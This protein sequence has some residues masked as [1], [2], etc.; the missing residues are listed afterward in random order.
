MRTAVEAGI[1]KPNSWELVV[2]DEVEEG[3]DKEEEEE[4]NPAVRNRRQSKE[5]NW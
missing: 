5:A 1:A 4:A 2:E 3:K